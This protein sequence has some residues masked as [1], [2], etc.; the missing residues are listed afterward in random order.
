MRRVGP[1]TSVSF[2]SSRVE[3]K[4]SQALLFDAFVAP[5]RGSGEWSFGRDHEGR[6]C[7]ADEGVQRPAGGSGGPVG[8]SGDSWSH[9]PASIP[10]SVAHGDGAT[11]WDSVERGAPPHGASPR[12]PLFWCH[13]E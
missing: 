4:K 1:H 12:R 3:E 8:G 13:H 10:C 5:A 7:G 2:F 6:R 11:C 9:H